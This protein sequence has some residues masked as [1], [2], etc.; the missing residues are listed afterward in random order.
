M[1]LA[2]SASLSVL[3]LLGLG[4]HLVIGE[5]KADP[6]AEAIKSWMEVAAWA[7]GLVLLFLHLKKELRPE[8]TND[9][10]FATK[11]EVARVDTDAK[12]R[13]ASHDS[14]LQRLEATFNEKHTQNV[15]KLDEVSGKLDRNH[16]QDHA[17]RE[18]MRSDVRHDV[19]E[20]V[21]PLQHRLDL[22]AEVTTEQFQKL[23]GELGGLKVAK[24]AS[25]SHAREVRQ[26]LNILL[27]RTAPNRGGGHPE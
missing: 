6:A 22:Q 17:E 11:E 25:D 12:A 5:F 1:P 13:D 20:L 18:R 10:K 3:S 14:A 7:A 15:R 8:P 4:M 26:T 27:S 16:D 23:A 21:Q 9:K 2:V 24:E 19:K